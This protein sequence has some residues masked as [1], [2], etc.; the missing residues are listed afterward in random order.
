MIP[1]CGELDSSALIIDSKERVLDWDGDDGVGD[2]VSASFV[3]YLEDY[4]NL[5]LSGSIEFIPGIGAVET[6]SKK[7][8]PR[9]K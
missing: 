3:N 2:I 4:R 8:A 9:R 7:A 6:T 5:L 1:F